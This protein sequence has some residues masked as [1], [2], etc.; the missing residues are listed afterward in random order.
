MSED[1]AYQIMRHPPSFAKTYGV[2]SNV[3]SRAILNGSIVAK[4]CTGRIY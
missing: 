4:K 3:L 1:A 2:Y